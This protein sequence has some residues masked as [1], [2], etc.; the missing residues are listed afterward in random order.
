MAENNSDGPTSCLKKM[1]LTPRLNSLIR[2]RFHLLLD[3][4]LDD[5]LELGVESEVKESKESNLN[6][7]FLRNHSWN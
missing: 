1:K 5:M 7:F 3:R 4:V 6:S 2:Q